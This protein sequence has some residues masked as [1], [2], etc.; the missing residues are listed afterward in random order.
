MKNQKILKTLS[1]LF[2]TLLLFVIIQG[3]G[4]KE[5]NS[6]DDKKSENKIESKDLVS[7]DKPV[8]VEFELSG[9]VSG[10]FKTYYKNK[11]MK[12]ESVM[13][14]GGGEAKSTMYSDG[15]TIYTITEA[16]G[17]KM[18]MKMDASKFYDPSNKN[19]KSFDFS[20]FKDKMKDYT[21]IG[22]EDVIGKHCDIYQSNKESKLKM[23]VYKELIPLKMQTDKMTMV[24][25]KLDVDVN[26]NDDIFVPPSDVKY[27]DMNSMMEDMKNPDKMKDMQE[28]MKQMEEGMKNYKK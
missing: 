2:L 1:R 10:T 20:A 15:S 3:C 19:N 11:K 12:T 25:T 5:N 4:K 27:T 17:T 7:L 13:K 21:K 6:S 18:G 9:D 28:Q 14:V 16:A 23:W 22:E 26:V 24:A 8:Y